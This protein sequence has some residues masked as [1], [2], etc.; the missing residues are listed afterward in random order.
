MNP[1]RLPPG[2]VV[3]V[4]LA[5]FLALLPLGHTQSPQGMPL[6]RRSPAVTAAALAFLTW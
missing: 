4:T 3:L 2:L 1:R 6:R 5:A